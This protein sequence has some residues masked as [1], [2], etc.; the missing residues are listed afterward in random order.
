VR[1]ENVISWNLA[2]ILSV[3]LMIG[4]LWA[5]MGIASHVFYRKSRASS[6]GVAANGNGDLLVAA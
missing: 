5:A 6:G 2:N 1:D 4:L 3:W